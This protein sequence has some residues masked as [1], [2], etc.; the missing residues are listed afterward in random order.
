MKTSIKRPRPH[1]TLLAA[2]GVALAVPLLG[3]MADAATAVALTDDNRLFRFDTASPGNVR[4]NVSVSG[5]AAGESLIG[6][7]F[8]PAVQGQLFGL[9]SFGQ[10]Y[11]I[12]AATGRATAVGA[13][14]SPDAA[15]LKGEKYGFDFNPTVD[16][17]RVVSDLGENLRLNPND[18]S[19]AG[20]DTKLAYKSGD[21]NAGVPPGVAAVAYTNNDNDAS[22]GT[23]LFG[24]DSDSGV[25]V[26]IDPPNGGVLNT[27]GSLGLDDDLPLF[28]GFDIF[29]EDNTAIAATTFE[30]EFGSLPALDATAFSI[31]LTTGKAT[32][33]G[34]IG[35]G[36]AQ[37]T[38][39]AAVPLPGAALVFPLGAALAGLV[40]YRIRRK[41]RDA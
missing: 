12:D 29:G 22:T 14:L 30:A 40:H 15:P 7:D 39:L 3:G 19:V 6:I 24:I 34:V 25:L 18:G 1:R 23:T 27:V 26:T 2:A 32:P 11:R 17:V 16:R 35:D 13:P 41:M 38:G 36:S 10:S 21:P 28:G 8:R 31:D 33:L 20:T 37:I 5:L 4:G 9:G